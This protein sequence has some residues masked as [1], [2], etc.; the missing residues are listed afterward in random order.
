[1][2]FGEDM[3]SSGVHADIEEAS[4]LA[5]KAIRKYAMG[6]D[7]IYLAVE[8]GLNEDAFFLSAEYATEAIRI[9]R[10][11]EHEA[12][13]I[14]TK[15]KLLLLKMAEYLTVNSRMDGAMVE[16]YVRKYG[17]EEWIVKE[18][19]IKRHEYYRFNSALQK[20]IANLENETFDSEIERIIA[21][22][23]EENKVL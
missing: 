5:N 4:R 10:S 19:L 11:C 17:Q 20:H 16:A 15:N 22:V 6:S 1:M 2:I 3:T 13:K 23:N 18:G 9:I 8:S 21:E 12:E 7:P 14:L